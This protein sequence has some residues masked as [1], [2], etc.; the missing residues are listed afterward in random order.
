MNLTE[1]TIGVART[2]NLGNF[3]SLRVEASVSASLENASEIEP[4]RAVLLVEVRET[5]RRAY[6]EFR[7][8]PKEGEL[9]V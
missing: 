2:F 4:A 6:V 5:L 3:E 8:K 9:D 1:I 7:P